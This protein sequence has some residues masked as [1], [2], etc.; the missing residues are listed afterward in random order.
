VS[1]FGRKFSGSWATSLGALAAREVASPPLT[2]AASAPIGHGRGNM[3]RH[4][5][6]SHSF[7]FR[8]C[9][10]L[11]LFFP[12]GLSSIGW[13]ILQMV[14]AVGDLKWCGGLW[15]VVVAG[16]RKGG[17]PQWHA[18]VARREFRMS[19]GVLYKCCR[20]IPDCLSS[21]P[22]QYPNMMIRVERD[23]KR[24]GRETDRVK[25]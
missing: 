10:A 6:H 5:P 11:L 19:A 14:V 23:R 16:Q 13:G 15:C 22:V 1:S 7:L 25:T 20:R 4:N 2:K 24:G 9:T 17:R 18:S 21:P 8:Y 3:T 12:S